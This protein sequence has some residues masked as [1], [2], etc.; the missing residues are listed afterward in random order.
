MSSSPK[1]LLLILEF[2]DLSLLVLL[3]VLSLLSYEK[4]KP[5]Y[6]LCDTIVLTN[7]FQNKAEKNTKMPTISSLV[8]FSA[9]VGLTILKTAEY[10][11]DTHILHILHAICICKTNKCI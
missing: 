9:P 11:E 4:L 2:N 8:S 1:V 7:N 3:I 5:A 6:L 10:Q